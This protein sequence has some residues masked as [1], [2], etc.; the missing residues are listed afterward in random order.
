MKLF[1]RLVLRMLPAPFFG[2]LGMLMF[3]LLMQFLIR[4]LPDIV[5]KG[6]P[7]GVIFELIAYNLAYM[8]VLAVPM[9]VLIAALMA[10]GRLAETNAYLVIK[11]S[12]VSLLQLAWPSF[13][14]ALIVTAGMG[15][16]NNEILPEANFRAK[17]LWQDIR[18]TK[19]G[20]ELQPGVFYNGLR[21]YTIMA[22]DIPPRSNELT[23]VLIYDS[24]ETSGQEAL[25]KA[26][27][28]RIMPQ[29]RGDV[30][31]LILEDGEVHQNQSVLR[32]KPMERYQRLSF[33]RFRIR[34]DLSDFNFERSDPK[35]G[36]RSD[37]TM[38]TEDMRMLVDSLRTSIAHSHLQLVDYGM[39]LVTSQP[40]R[41]PDRLA[42]PAS[43]D[44]G[45][46]SGTFRDHFVTTAGLD[47]PTRRILFDEAMQKVRTRHMEIDDIRRT[48]LW[49][50]RRLD[51]Y[52]V[53]IHKKYSIAFACII[54]LLIGA[55][56]GLRIKR[57]GLGTA[58]ALAVGIFL[59]YWVTLVQGEKMADRDML[60]PWFGMWIA[61]IVVAIAGA[62]LTFSH[63]L[64]IRIFPRRR[65]SR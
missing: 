19:P 9:S 62:F 51:R 23:D 27:R 46:F 15:Y 44:S 21:G 33:D 61:N 45:S 10:F 54:F 64:H 1:H 52:R 13:I 35:V 47:G 42:S 6:L 55:P 3:L 32:D 41:E 14:L 53:E 8:V 28:G 43:I 2:W 11:S 17:N 12:G 34:F 20:F 7:F 38:R 56:L 36:Y 18:R 4:Y 50:S 25:I 37:R 16:F 31:D 49:E 39:E 65:G 29:Q 59:F 60:S 63:I 48:I 30:V 26:V 40:T 58:G 22:R 5:G 57:G 24:G